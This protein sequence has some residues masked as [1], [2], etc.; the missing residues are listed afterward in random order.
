MGHLNQIRIYTGEIFIVEKDYV[1]ISKIKLNGEEINTNGEI[2]CSV[3]KNENFQIG[4]SVKFGEL[5]NDKKRP[6]QFKTKK[7]LMKFDPDLELKLKL[8]HQLLTIDSAREALSD[9]RYSKLL[10]GELKGK[11]LRGQIEDLISLNNSHSDYYIKLL[12]DIRV[13]LL[14]S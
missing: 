5:N 10:E 12:T 7:I 14:G 11:T 8:L 1:L 3:L 2:F 13:Y 6:G 9:P 4:Q